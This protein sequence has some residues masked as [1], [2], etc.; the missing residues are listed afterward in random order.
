MQV[1]SHHRIA[2]GDYKQ[3]VSHLIDLVHESKPLFCGQ[4]FRV[5]AGLC[6]CAAVATGQRTSPGHFPERDKRI[7]IKV[8]LRHRRPLS[9]LASPM[10][11]RSHCD[12]ARVAKVFCHALL[13]D[14]WTMFSFASMWSAAS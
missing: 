7:D 13:S 1:L 3:R 8:H 10:R 6:L 11:T 12:M 14:M 2:T 5:A 4:F 9:R